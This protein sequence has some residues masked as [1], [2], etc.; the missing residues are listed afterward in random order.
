MQ[1]P[2]VRLK[3]A[4]EFIQHNSDAKEA[5]EKILAEI[6]QDPFVDGK[7]KFY[8]PC[9]PIIFT[10]YRS[11][12]FRVLYCLETIAGTKQAVIATIEYDQ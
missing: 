8:Y 2:I 7:I 3:P 9:P 6:S 11:N 5:I 4:D 1:Y 10:L 12:G